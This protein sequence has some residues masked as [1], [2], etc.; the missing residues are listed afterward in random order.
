MLWIF[1]LLGSAVSLGFYDVCKKHAVHANSVMSAM[2]L[3]TLFGT[4]G[5][6]L[7]QVFS[8]HL[9]GALSLSAVA[10]WMIV[11]KSVIVT[12]SW[13][14]GDYALRSLPIS[15]AAPIRGSQPVLTL[16]GALLLFQERP[17]A[18]QWAG[19]GITIVAY[20]LFSIIGQREGIHF[21]RNK[22]IAL[23]FLATLL[24]AVSS[25]YDKY[26]LQPAKLSPEL[27]QFWFQVDLVLILGILLLLQRRVGLSRTSFQFRWS[28]PAVGL[29][30][31]ASDWMY[32]TVLSHPQA[33]LAVVSPVRRSSC[34]I[35]FLVGGAMFK[36][37]NRRS[38]AVA[39]CCIVA[40]VVLLCLARR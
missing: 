17:D 22:G 1:L 4:A 12:S 39:L 40:G 20:F 15:I 8:G 33:M 25:L 30:L 5:M 28:I 16:I 34:V 2:F 14:C 24:G 18:L 38:K 23:V 37:R 26:L 21:H 27:V 10:W 29:L 32:F 7:A 6:V 36:D 31:V 3:A 35:A 13:I 9:S 11:L 19:I